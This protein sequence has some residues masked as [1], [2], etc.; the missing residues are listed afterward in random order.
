MAGAQRCALGG[1]FMSV[2]LAIETSTAHYGM[3]LGVGGIVRAETVAGPDSERDLA[4]TLRDLLVHADAAVSDIDAIGVDIGPGSLGSL[5][6]GANFANALGYALHIP[7]FAFTSFELVG[8]AVAGEL[9]VLCVRRANEGL[10]YAG[11]YAEG[12]VRRMR[13]GALEEIVND[14]AGRI[15]VDCAGALAAEAAALLPGRVRH[16]NP[17][18]PSVQTIIRIGVEGRAACDPLQS[19]ALPLNERAA[20]F[21]N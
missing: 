6:D 3:A 7:V 8:R 1:E 21:H 17:A 18:G 10:A 11:L 9:P 12:A 4:R 20:V 19:P 13:W 5:R 16:V 15:D 14:V 2:L